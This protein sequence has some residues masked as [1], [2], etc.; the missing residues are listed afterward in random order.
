V[1][2][3]K[4]KKHSCPDCKQCQQC[5]PTRC[6]LCRGQGADEAERRFSGLSMAEQIALFEA[7]NRGETPEGRYGTE[8]G[9]YGSDLFQTMI[10]PSG[11]LL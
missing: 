11:R 1:T 2:T 6:H 8:I 9:E 10:Q 4:Q 3:C 5:S 7:V